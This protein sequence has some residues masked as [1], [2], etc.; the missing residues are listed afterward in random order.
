M[1][2]TRLINLRFSAEQYEL[3]KKKMEIY[4]YVNMSQYIRD[5][6][7]RDDFS[8]LVMIRDIHKKIIG[9]KKNDENSVSR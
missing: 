1:C 8:T 6:S 5:C 4:G 3:L 7:L 9:D 2:R